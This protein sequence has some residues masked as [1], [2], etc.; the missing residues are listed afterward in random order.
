M[1]FTFWFSGA[2]LNSTNLS[3]QSALHSAAETGQIK[4]VQ[5]LIEEKIDPFKVDMFKLKAIDIAKMLNRH[6]IQEMLSN[7]EQVFE[8]N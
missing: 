6:E 7:Y 1:I 2:N 4:V 5:F 3:G 8:K